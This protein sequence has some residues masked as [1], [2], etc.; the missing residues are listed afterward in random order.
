MRLQSCGLSLPDKSSREHTG[1]WVKSG[2]RADISCVTFSK[3]N[4]SPAE[5]VNR[6]ENQTAQMPQE[7][8][9]ARRQ[10]WRRRPEPIVKARTAGDQ[11]RWPDAC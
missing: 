4:D 1:I 8:A 9:T 7:V 10:G 5:P 3:G 11:V 6:P 2:R